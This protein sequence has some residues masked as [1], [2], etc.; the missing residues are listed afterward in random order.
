MDEK[1][2]CL[3]CDSLYAAEES[4]CPDCGFPNISLTSGSEEEKQKIADMAAQYRKLHFKGLQDLKIFLS[5]SQN[6]AVGMVVSTKTSPYWYLGKTEALKESVIFWSDM[7]F[8]RQDRDVSVRICV[9]NMKGKKKYYRVNLKDLKTTGLRR[10]GLLRLK[11]ELHLVLGDTE[12][13][14]MSNPIPV[15]ADF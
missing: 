7:A 4:E 1:I 9:E 14:T 6:K 13:Y 5:A 11:G 15:P 8:A 2:K 12:G 10:L 3:V